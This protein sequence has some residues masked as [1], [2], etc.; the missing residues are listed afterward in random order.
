MKLW[1]AIP[2]LALL[3]AMQTS[4]APSLDIG[5]ARPQLVLVFVICWAVVRG[6]AEALPWAIFGGLLLDL[7]SSLP[8][9]AHLVALCL[10]AFGADLGHRFLH[11][12]NLLFAVVAVLLGSVAYGGLLLLLSG[13]APHRDL[14]TAALSH[15]VLPGAVY[16]LALMFPVLALLRAFDRRFP[17]PL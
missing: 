4:L 11:G 5:G 9:G 16:N 12:S 7:L 10:V 6:E 14:A 1:L 15:Q 13:Y 8:T 3:T 17:R 2:M